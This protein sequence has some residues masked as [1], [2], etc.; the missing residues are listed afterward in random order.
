MVFNS[1][2]WTIGKL[3]GAAV[4]LHWTVAAFA[5][6]FSGFRFAPGIWLGYVLLV[7]VHEAGHALF[8]RRYGYRV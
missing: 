6:Y 7:L 5:L 4:P 3:G 1:G 8:V 2:Y